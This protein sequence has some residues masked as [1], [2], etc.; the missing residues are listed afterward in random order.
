M[1]KV[2]RSNSESEIFFVQW[3]LLNRCNLRCRHCYQDDY[4]NL[5]PDLD[6]ARD[7]ALEFLEDFGSLYGRIEFNLTGGEPLLYPHLYEL[8]T[9]ISSRGG[10]WNLLTNGTLLDRVAVCQLQKANVLNVQISLEGLEDDNDLIRGRGSFKKAFTG[11]QLLRE[12]GVAVTLAMTLTSRNISKLGDLLEFAERQK[13]GI[14]FHRYIPVAKRGIQ[15][16]SLQPSAGE[17]REAIRKLTSW[18]SLDGG[19]AKMNDPLFCRYALETQRNPAQASVH[20]SRQLGCS[21]GVSGV[22]V[23]P[24]GEIFPCRK[25]PIVLGNVFEESLMEVWL[26]S[27]QLW[28]LRDRGKYHGKCGNCSASRLCGGCR[29]SAY[30]NSINRDSLGEDRLCWY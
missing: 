28:R 19:R 17:W 9:L 20:S 2:G 7:F 24:N 22:T 11:L 1:G 27:P 8:A 6:S 14:G 29:A 18:R 4:S 16:T 25:L 12:E 23:M 15:Q 13:V 26:R 10:R 3:H 5:E 30:W 21:I